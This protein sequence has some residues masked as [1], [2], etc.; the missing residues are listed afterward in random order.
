META[1]LMD[2]NKKMHYLEEE[3]TLP[4]LLKFLGMRYSEVSRT[5][6]NKYH[7][8]YGFVEDGTMAIEV[9]LEESKVRFHSEL[10]TYMD[11]KDDKFWNI[12]FEARLEV[13]YRLLG[14]FEEKY[15]DLG[16]ITFEYFT[17][18]QLEAF[19]VDYGFGW[20]IK[21]KDVGKKMQRQRISMNGYGRTDFSQE[22]MDWYYKA[23]KLWK[24]YE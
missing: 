14:L 1:T 10:G 7:D 17:Y 18:G 24:P 8:V 23:W 15:S 12:L 4:K 13:V 2:L 22:S 21:W 9:F 6:G 11:S 20:Q 5:E 19:D 3:A 16:T